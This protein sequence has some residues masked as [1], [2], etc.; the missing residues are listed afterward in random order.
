MTNN[1]KELAKKYLE[2]IKRASSLSQGWI[3]K[4]VAPQHFTLLGM[5]SVRDTDENTQRSY[6][7][8]YSV[9]AGND[10]VPWKDAIPWKI[11]SIVPMSVNPKCVQYDISRSG[12]LSVGFY[13]S[14]IGTAGEK[15]EKG[16]FIEI[17]DNEFGL[18]RVDTST[19]HGKIVGDSWFGGCS[20]SSDENFIAYIAQI[21]DP[22]KT[23]VEQLFSSSTTTTTAATTDSFNNKN[24]YDY[25]ED[26]GEKYVEV[27]DL[28]IFVL[29][30]ATQI[31]IPIALLDAEDYTCG[32]PNFIQNA[33]DE[34]G[35]YLL[36]YT[37]WN[38]K[39]RRLGM[40]YCYQRNSSVWIADI[41]ST[42]KGANEVD[43]SPIKTTPSLN[44]SWILSE[45]I[46]IA[47]SV[48]SSPSGKSLVFLGH[49][50]GFLTHNGCS[51]L[52]SVDLSVFYEF[53]SKQKSA[54]AK[55]LTVEITRRRVVDEIRNYSS[56]EDFPGLFI[57]Q[58]PKN[59]F[60]NENEILCTSLWESKE[61]L[62]KIDLKNETV[63]QVPWWKYL[64]EGDDAN[65]DMI[66]QYSFQLLDVNVDLGNWGKDGLLVIFGQISSPVRPSQLVLL[67][68][69]PEN[70]HHNSL[71]DPAISFG[72]PNRSYSISSKWNFPLT[73]SPSLNLNWT[74][75]RH[76]ENGINF[77]SILFYPTSSSS[78]QP[79]PLVVV[80]H[81]GPHS[82]LT[83]SFIGSYVFLARACQVGILFVNFRGST[84]FGQDSIDSLLGNIGTND[85]Q[86]LWVA[87]RH[88]LTY[89]NGEGSKVIDETRLGIIGGSHGGFLAAHMCGQH[90]ESFKMA[91]LRNPVTNI[92]AM[93]SV[94]DIPD[95]CQ[96]ESGSLIDKANNA[97]QL[98]HG[99]INEDSLVKMF[100][101]SPVRYIQQYKTPTLI[102]LGAKDRRV[103]VSQGIEF[104]HLLQLNNVTSK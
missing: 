64:K 20:W 7:E 65:D 53:P 6:F 24:K 98:Y 2:E 17:V 59:C 61:A 78:T 8:N 12:R 51:E 13:N 79:L 36:A 88:A 71:D 44:C 22:K 39:P 56:P 43:S 15:K 16:S 9:D 89:E 27:S 38:N 5:R 69:D 50:K 34:N 3:R 77:N 102:C 52:F 10:A 60:L 100:N 47:R 40:I 66:Y 14:G 55:E 73:P 42:L 19:I 103:P 26:W 46:E 101:A 4:G 93:A 49:E 29:D 96:I 76:Q 67:K 92:P 58:L 74:I 91:C 72:P 70:L 84:G 18:F 85:V 1:T 25:Q 68:V 21:H 63:Q 81:G 31:V 95:W 82:C 62:M 80:P 48:R 35:K 90:P 23:V 41:T 37:A 87:I 28:G 45:G 75:F 57:D 86:D 94:T 97:N 104:Y 11:T 83:N 32:Q 99:G 54:S 30:I 33:A